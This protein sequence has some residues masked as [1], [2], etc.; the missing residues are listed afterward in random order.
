MNTQ[1]ELSVALDFEDWYSINYDQLV[2]N[3]TDENPE[4]FGN[5]DAWEDIENKVIFQEFCDESY[6]TY[7]DSLILGE[8]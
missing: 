4:Y 1:D 5:S 7:R 8:D 3:C 6:S 2:T